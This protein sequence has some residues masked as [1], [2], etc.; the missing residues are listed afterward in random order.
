MTQRQD[1]AGSAAHRARLGLLVEMIAAGGQPDMRRYDAEREI[2]SRRGER[3]PAA[4][5]LVGTYGHWL[6]ARDAALNVAN[7]ARKAPAAGQRRTEVQP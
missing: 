3:W 2:R 4:R 1:L 7:P 6:A 5:S